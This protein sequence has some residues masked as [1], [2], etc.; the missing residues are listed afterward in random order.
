MSKN[1]KPKP[2]FIQLYIYN[3]ILIIFSFLV[4][5]GHLFFMMMNFLFIFSLLNKMKM[6]I[7]I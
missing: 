6:T 1:T 7:L 5:L 3:L 2:I 4:W